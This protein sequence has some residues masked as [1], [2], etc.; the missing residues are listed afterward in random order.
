MESGM[1]GAEYPL[2]HPQVVLFPQSVFEKVWTRAWSGLV[3]TWQPGNLG[4]TE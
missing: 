3:R 4:S 1:M 2:K